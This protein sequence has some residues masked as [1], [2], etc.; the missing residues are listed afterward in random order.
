[1]FYALIQ[2]HNRSSQVKDSILKLFR[3][4]LLKGNKCPASGY[5]FEK[6]LIDLGYNYRKHITCWKCQ[7]RL[8]EGDIC[9]NNHC[10]NV[11]TQGKG[12]ESI[13]FYIID[14][15]P[16]IEKVISSKT[17]FDCWS[18]IGPHPPF[19]PPSPKKIYVYCQA[20][21]KVFTCPEN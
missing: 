8:R 5:Q 9:L 4:S 10:A 19:P 17:N 3:L 18:C 15:L 20:V 7:H 6:S 11:G 21:R 1:M 12:E 13:M 2:K 16:E 14:L